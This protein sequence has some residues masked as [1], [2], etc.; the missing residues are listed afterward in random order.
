[1]QSEYSLW[2]SRQTADKFVDI[3]TGEEKVCVCFFNCLVDTVITE[4]GERFPVIKVQ[5]A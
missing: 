2:L 3:G 1:M 5:M 4:A